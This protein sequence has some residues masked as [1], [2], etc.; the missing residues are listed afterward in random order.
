MG[1]G[2]LEGCTNEM[3]AYM[4]RSEIQRVGGFYRGKTGAGEERVRG[5]RGGSPM[6]KKIY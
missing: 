6:Q 5:I 4:P 1:I 3:G 2:V